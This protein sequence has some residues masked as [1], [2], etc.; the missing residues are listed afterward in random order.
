MRRSFRKSFKKHGFKKKG[1]KRR[2][3]G[4]KSKRYYTI[5]RGGIRL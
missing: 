2:R 3:G 1:Y 5:S 4:T